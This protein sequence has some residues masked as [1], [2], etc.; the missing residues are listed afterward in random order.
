MSEKN[1]YKPLIII[2]G[3]AAAA[4]LISKFR[5]SYI[6]SSRSKQDLWIHWDVEFKK[7]SSLDEINR[8]MNRTEDYVLDYLKSKDI[9]GLKM[10]K[11]EF[12]FKIKST[13]ATFKVFLFSEEVSIERVKHPRPPLPPPIIPG[14]IFNKFRNVLVFREKLGH[15]DPAFR[16]PGMGDHF[17]NP[18]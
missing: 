15:P 4:L 2:G 10:Y 18:I 16:D 13:K 5:K 12:S 1:N 6:G 14:D 8:C 3:V 17:S 9:S 7:G 11:P